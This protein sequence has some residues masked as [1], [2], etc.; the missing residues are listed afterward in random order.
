MANICPSHASRLIKA[1]KAK[2]APE[3][4]TSTRK[5]PLQQTCARVVHLNQARPTKT[6]LVLKLCTSAKKGPLRWSL[7]L[8]HAPRLEDLLGL[9]YA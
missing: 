9:T 1:T 8:S 7:Y 3:S 6:K 4:C 5:G 2:P